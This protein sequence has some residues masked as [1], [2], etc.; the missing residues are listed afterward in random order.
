[1]EK[2][3]RSVLLSG[4]SSNAANGLFSNS[5]EAVFCNVKQDANED[6]ICSGVRGLRLLFFEEKVSGGWL[7]RGVDGG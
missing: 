3:V 5:V 6:D 4:P 2:C 1:M 7:A